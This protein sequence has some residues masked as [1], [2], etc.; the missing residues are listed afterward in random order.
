M[1]TV[2][3]TETAYLASH[4]SPVKQNGCFSLPQ[5]QADQFFTVASR[6]AGILSN[7]WLI[8]WFPSTCLPCFRMKHLTGYNLTAAACEHTFVL[9]I[10][11]VQ[12]EAAMAYIYMCVYTIRPFVVY[13]IKELCIQ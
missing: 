9:L 10:G 12:K 11:T 5:D 4:N 7:F 8:L 3:P 1:L 13:I 2:Y 6:A